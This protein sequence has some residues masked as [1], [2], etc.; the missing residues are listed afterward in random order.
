M[1]W[2]C[3]NPEADM[4]TRA[5]NQANLYLRIEQ[6]E[7]FLEAG[8]EFK[9][10]GI[11]VKG[12]N[13]PCDDPSLHARWAHLC[14]E[15][16]MAGQARES[17]ER[18][19][20]V[21]PGD[22]EILFSLANLLHGTGHYEKS[23]HYLKKA[24]KVNPSHAEARHLLSADYRALGLCGQAETLHPQGK[25]QP[26]P[27]RYFP[28]SISKEQIELFLTL[29]SGRE[30]AHAIQVLNRETGDIS[31]EFQAV[32]LNHD[33]IVAHIRGTLTLAAYSLR[34]DKTVKYVVIETRLRKRVLESNLKNWAY[35]TYLNEKALQHCLSLRHIAGT[36]GI[37]AYVDSCGDHRHRL[38][39]FFREFIHFLK[40]KAFMDRLLAQA[41]EPDSKLRIEPIIGTRP[42]GIGWIE[43]A[44][45]LP[46]GMNKANLNRCLFLDDGGQ[47]Y[48]KQLQFL[49]KIREISSRDMRKA[50]RTSG[51][52]GPGAKENILSESVALLLGAC[53][54]LDELARRAQRGRIL[55]YE[56]KV[57]LFYTIGLVGE[58]DEADLHSLLENC[59]DYNYRKVA[60]QAARLR[61][62]PMSCQKIR[63]LVPEITASVACNCSFDLRGGKYPS[64]LLH[65]NPHLVP[66]RPELDVNEKMPIKEA[67]KRYI[68]MKRQATEL[69][70]AMERVSVILN[71]H[72]DNSGINR[73]RAGNGILIRRKERRAT[74]WEI[75]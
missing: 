54:V 57:I 17:Y 25:K 53:P 56:E 60:R 26:K 29:F 37:P 75:G 72:C 52:Q 24:I 12:R 50:F 62:N 20:K 16:G 34:T 9:A 51:K 7:E 55:S 1:I 6:A 3:V 11:V 30:D 38:W 40:A 5:R 36:F 39:F 23:I 28:P 46:L 33:L 63:E 8:D 4:N 71:L 65:L 64:P 31:F 59:P 43:R 27:I 61:Q 74:F 21:C 14:E 15:L 48:G 22:S 19:L 73:I 32:P 47:P 10:R 49:A 41:P 67:A 66:S 42:I 44:I 13:I 35:L 58:E 70:R 18:A 69:E 45:L 2:A 68:T